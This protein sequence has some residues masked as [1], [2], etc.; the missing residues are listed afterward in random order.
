MLYLR[1]PLRGSGVRSHEAAARLDDEQ[2]LFRESSEELEVEANIGAGYLIFQGTR[3]MEHALDHRHSLDVPVALAADAGASIHA[4]VR[5][6]VENHPDAMA[7]LVT[8]RHRKSNGTVPIYVRAV[9]AA[10]RRRFRAVVDL[11]GSD[12]QIAEGLL[13]DLL[14]GAQSAGAVSREHLSLGSLLPDATLDVRVTVEAFDNQYNYFFLLQPTHRIE[15]G[16]RITARAT[17]AGP[18]AH[19]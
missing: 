17:S 18:V 7:L 5:Y 19:R 2:R 16:R 15:L 12:L 10:W 13:H 3:W 4:A 11:F 8:G 9:S 14:I 6:Y 1:I